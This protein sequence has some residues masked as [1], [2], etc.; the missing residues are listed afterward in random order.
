MSAF[1]LIFSGRGHPLARTRRFFPLVLALCFL[2]LVPQ[3][4]RAQDKKADAP[5]AAPAAV[6]SAEANATA[7]PTGPESYADYLARHQ[8][9][10]DAFNDKYGNSIL[11]A[12]LPGLFKIA[13]HFAVL[14]LIYNAIIQLLGAWICAKFIVPLKATWKRAGTFSGVQV[15]T[16]LVWVLI[17]YGLGRVLIGDDPTRVSLVSVVILILISLALG[18][19]LSIAAT[20][21]VYKTNISTSTVFGVGL[22]VISAV[23]NVLFFLVFSILFASTMP[24]VTGHYGKPIFIEC[25]LPFVN[26]ETTEVQKQYDVTSV[27]L[28]AAR[29]KQAD[30]DAQTAE[31]QQ[32]VEAMKQKIAAKDTSDELV[33]ARLGEIADRGKLPQTLAAYEGFIKDRPQSPYVAYA[34]E[35]IETTKAD[36]EH[37]SAQHEQAQAE[38]AR[39]AAMADSVLKEKLSK[40]QATLSEVRTALLGKSRDEVTALLGAP[41]QTGS[42]AY[43]YDKV[44]VLEPVTGRQRP[45]AVLFLEGNVKTVNYADGK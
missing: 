43:L 27:D 34:K 21:Y 36:M 29:K 42:D 18:L 15:G 41:T 31:A 40:N 1:K 37:M 35:Q 32:Q 5:A 22:T 17:C 9:N 33:Y 30:V 24:E 11:K 16:S 38:L 39:S 20:K 28:D 8:A 45:F 4:G 26:K 44:L 25:I 12:S 13:F 23:L 3:I 19:G 10:Y 6:Q 2:A 14:F 7:A